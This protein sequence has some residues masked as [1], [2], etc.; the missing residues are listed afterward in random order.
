[1]VN[2]LATICHRSDPEPGMKRTGQIFR[3]KG[4]SIG[5]PKDASLMEIYHT[6]KCDGSTKCICCQPVSLTR[7]D[8]HPTLLEH[9]EEKAN[10]VKRFN[11]LTHWSSL[12]I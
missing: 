5:I 3:T 4:T 2:N 1:M 8:L 12:A 9:S 11:Q 10:A 6:D 7:D